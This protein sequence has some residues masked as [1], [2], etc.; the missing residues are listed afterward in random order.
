MIVVTPIR[1]NKTQL[2]KEEK[3]RLEANKK[4][5]FVMNAAYT[6]FDSAVSDRRS[7]VARRD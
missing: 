2:E 3:N 1:Y 5:T 6:E 7:A 4:A